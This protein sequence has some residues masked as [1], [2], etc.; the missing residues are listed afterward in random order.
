M[1]E[2]YLTSIDYADN[3]NDLRSL[4]FD[5]DT[6]RGFLSNTDVVQLKFAIAHRDTYINT[7]NYGVYCGTNA[8]GFTFVIYG[9]NS[10]GQIVYTSNDKVMEHTRPCPSFCVTSA[11]L[12]Y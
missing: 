6:M 3:S 2:S 9:L 12:T 11:L 1:I 8:A 7:G 10:S 4:T 5:A